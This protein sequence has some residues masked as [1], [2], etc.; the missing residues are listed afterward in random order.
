MRRLLSLLIGLGVLGASFVLGVPAANAATSGAG[1][2]VAIEGEAWSSPA[3]PVECTGS[4]HA[5]RVSCEPTNS[6]DITEEF[7]F[8]NVGLQGGQLATVCSTFEGNRETIRDR[9][10]GGELTLEYGCQFGDA[11]CLAAEQ[12]SRAMS[13]MV[14][15]GLAWAIGNASFS[16]D[17]Y[18][19]DA[20][21][22]EWSW[23]QGVTL[24]VI[25]IAGIVSL[26]MSLWSRD[27]AELVKAFARFFFTLPASMFSV[28]MLGN[29]ANV[30]DD[31]TQ[32]IIGRDDGEGLYMTIQNMVY[33]TASGNFFMATGVLVLFTAATVVLLF[34]FSFR[35]FALASLIALG[36]VAFMLF[37]TSF[38][39]QWVLRWASAV[40]ALLLTTPL[41]LGVMMLVLRGFGT[42]E[43]LWSIQAIPLA[44]GLLM[45]V[46]APMAVFGLFSFAGNAIAGSVAENGAANMGRAAMG[47]V[48][49]AGRAGMRAIGSTG[50]RSAAARAALQ[51]NRTA[52]TGGGNRPSPGPGAG[53]K[54]NRPGP[55]PGSGGTPQPRPAQPT[56]Q[57]AAPAPRPAPAP[58]A[59]SSPPP[60]PAPAQ[61]IPAPQR[62]VT[63]PPGA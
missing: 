59:P 22:A 14:T 42:V 30:V 61:R 12:A 54:P 51:Q 26:M 58:S 36:P 45:L 44:I 21:I 63:P 49:G 9:S 43:T 6:T 20:A 46:F 3:F 24:V 29:L 11:V 5:P 55:Q 53:G 2:G 17:G 8:G 37:P 48:Q 31:I 10:D 18:L 41:T 27:R 39:V 23:W 28:W 47:K 57:S 35:N 50:A 60:G 40:T 62:R 34:V 38:G 32:G 13:T 16:T 15:G 4:Q 25:L 1:A 56:G 7:C 33:N 19:W 52:P